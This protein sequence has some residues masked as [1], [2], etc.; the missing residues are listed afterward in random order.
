MFEWALNSM[1]SDLKTEKREWGE[2]GAETHRG[3]GNVKVEKESEV[4]W[5][6]NKGVP[7]L[8]RIWKRQRMAS[9]LRALEGDCLAFSQTSSLRNAMKVS[10]CGFKPTSLW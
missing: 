7:T 4:M 3:E 2:G 6:K 8:T 1:T 9:P 5:P 10:S